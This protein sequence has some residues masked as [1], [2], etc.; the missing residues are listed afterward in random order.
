MRRGPLICVPLALVLLASGFSAAGGLGSVS[1]GQP[2]LRVLKR[3][4][5]VVQGLS[6]KPGERVEVV[7]YATAQTTRRA[8]AS[9]AGS[10]TVSFHEVPLGRCSSLAVR[11]AGSFGSRAALKLPAPAC[12]PA[13]APVSSA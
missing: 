5:L 12:L 3:Q 11:A 9:K 1:Q 2:S 8:T 4:P 10:F 13:R 6:F 7:L